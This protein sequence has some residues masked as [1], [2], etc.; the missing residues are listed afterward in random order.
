LKLKAIS[1]FD[2]L[3]LC[4]RGTVGILIVLPAT[5]QGDLILEYTKGLPPGLVVAQLEA[6]Q[7]QLQDIRLEDEILAHKAMQERVDKRGGESQGPTAPAAA[8]GPC[9]VFICWLYALALNRLITLCCAIA[10]SKPAG[11]LK[12]HRQGECLCAGCASKQRQ[13]HSTHVCM[14]GMDLLCIVII[15]PFHQQHQQTVWW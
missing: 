10:A 5:Q 12:K 2:N 7:Q 14:D 4:A 15:L 11:R 8:H 13:R 6:L 3:S 1:A 9:T